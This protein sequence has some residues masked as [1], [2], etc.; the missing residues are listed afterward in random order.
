MKRERLSR[1]SSLARFTLV[2]LIFLVLYQTGQLNFASLKIVTR[3]PDVL[4]LSLALISLWYPAIWVL[5]FCLYISE[6][7]FVHYLLVPA[8]CILVN[9]VPHRNRVCYSTLIFVTYALKR[10]AKTL[11]NSISSLR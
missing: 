6:L 8:L 3:K 9:T 2:A 11:E 4:L 7:E 1:F 10:P 5:A